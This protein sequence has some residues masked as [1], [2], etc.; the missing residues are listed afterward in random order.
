MKI[1]KEFI[2]CTGVRLF[3]ILFQVG[4]IEQEG[5][6]RKC[7]FQLIS[8]VEKLPPFGGFFPPQADV[9]AGLALFTVRNSITTHA[10]GICETSAIRASQPLQGPW[11][12]SA[13][14]TITATKFARK[15]L[16]NVGFDNEKNRKDGGGDY[17]MRW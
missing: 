3:P 10:Q 16:L 12:P 1:F 15:K 4:R 13:K 6:R 2:E 11:E 8:C 17:V 7:S 5:L 9:S 14:G